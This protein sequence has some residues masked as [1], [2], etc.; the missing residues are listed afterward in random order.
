MVSKITR[1]CVILLSGLIILT[2]FDW[3]LSHMS[4]FVVWSDIHIFLSSEFM[5]AQH[6]FMSLAMAFFMLIA[7]YGLT[8]RSWS[9][10]IRLGII[11]GL[12]IVLTGLV[13]IAMHI[14]SVPA[15]FLVNQLAPLSAVLMIKMILLTWSMAQVHTVLVN[16]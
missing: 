14:N 9:K 3:L 1:G 11:Y 13:N 10:R 4:G 16:K 2:G 7:V 6:V 8:M 12:I 15:A 5:S